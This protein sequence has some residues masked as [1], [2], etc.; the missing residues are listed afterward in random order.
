M[1]YHPRRRSRPD[2]ITNAEAIA[3]ALYFIGGM[4]EFTT[5]ENAMVRSGS[6]L[7]RTVD[8]FCEAI[9]ARYKDEYIRLPTKEEMQECMEYLEQERGIPQCIGA[10]DGKHFAITNGRKQHVKY[11]SPKK[12]MQQNNQQYYQNNTNNDCAVIK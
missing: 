9:I 6:S 4:V 10:I 12:V 5:Q 3:Q 7:T 1:P 11:Y 2:S 8:E